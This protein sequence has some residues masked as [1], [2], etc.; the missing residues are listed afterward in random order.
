MRDEAKTRE[1]LIRELAELRKRVAEVEKLESE[2]KQVERKLAEYEESNKLKTS[3]LDVVSHELRTP[4]ATI[5]GYSTML[6]DYDTRLQ[7]EEKLQHLKSIDRATDRLIKLVDHLL[8]MSRLEAG[9][10]KI[11]KAP[12]SITTLIRQAVAE[13]QAIA[14]LHKITRAGGERFPKVNIDAKLI[15]QVLDTLMSNAIKYSHEGSNI[16]VAARQVG[17]E[18]HISVADEGID[19][20][21]EAWDR[22]FNPMYRREQRLTP[23]AEGLGLELY[24][25]RGLVEAHGGRI[26]V[27]GN[28]GKGSKFVFT[29]P[30]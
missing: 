1:Q 30:L 21:P 27:E 24:V 3:L 2:H 9:L 22:V 23:A 16:L 20:P 29:I 25:C 26:W 19:I 28:D 5:R 4:L 10:L 12:T 6:L 11:H 15:R 17:S 13:G 18:L 14:P 7:S 8:D